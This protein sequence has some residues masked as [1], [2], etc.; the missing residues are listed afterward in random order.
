MPTKAALPP[1]TRAYLEGACSPSDVSLTV[2]I[3]KPIVTS[4]SFT[5]ISLA[6][7]APAPTKAI[8]FVTAAVNFVPSAAALFVNA[9]EPLI[10]AKSKTFNSRFVLTAVSRPS[11][12][13]VQRHRVRARTSRDG[14][15]GRV[16]LLRRVVYRRRAVHKVQHR[17]RRRLTAGPVDHHAQRRHRRRQALD[18]D[19]RHALQI[20][21][22][23]GHID[24]DGVHGYRLRRGRRG[25][26]VSFTTAVPVALAE[27]PPVR[28]KP[29][30]A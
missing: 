7:P 5:P 10:W 30:V 6:V 29:P 2:V 25:G 28:W 16:R 11:S 4:D 12:V 19:Q 8:A 21:F 17:V 27:S 24:C 3:T 18:P 9:H 23:R 15:A 26:G 22:Q 20:G 14:P 1:A 13:Q